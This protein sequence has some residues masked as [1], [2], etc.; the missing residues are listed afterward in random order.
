MRRQRTYKLI[1]QTKEAGDTN[2][3]KIVCFYLVGKNQYVEVPIIPKVACSLKPIPIKIPRAYFFI[4]LCFIEYP[5]F[6]GNH[7]RPQI[8]KAILNKN[9]A[10]GITL[11]DSKVKH[12]RNQNTT[13]LGINQS[14]ELRNKSTRLWL[15][16]FLFF[17]D[18]AKTT[19]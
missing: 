5:K 13:A 4:E 19:W 18:G 14:S 11:P 10:V 2:K 8:A 1:R 3:Y 15:P 7:S 17:N 9:N 16:V 12:Y 6:I